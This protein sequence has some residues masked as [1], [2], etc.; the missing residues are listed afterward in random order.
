VSVPEDIGLDDVEAA[1][2]GL[3]DEPRPH[4][5]EERRRTGS[6]TKQHEDQS[7]LTLGAE[8]RGG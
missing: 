8:S 6:R 7:N 2:L 3:L 1:V 5:E 4:L